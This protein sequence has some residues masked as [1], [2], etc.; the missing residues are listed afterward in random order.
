MIT[1]SPPVVGAPRRRGG[2]ARDGCPWVADLRD[3]LV[4]HPHRRRG[5]AARAREGAGRPRGRAARR[6]PGRRDRRAS[7]RR[8]PRRCASSTRRAGRDDRERL[9]LRRLRRARVHAPSD[10]RFR[11]THAGSFF[12]KRD[13]RPF[14]TALRDRA[15]RRRRA[16]PRRLPLD[17]PRVGG[18]AGL[19]DR[20]ELIPYAPHRRLARAAARLRGAAAPD[21]GGRR[22]R[23]GRA[24]REG[25]RVPRGRAADPRAR[26]AG[27]RGGGAAARDGRRRRGRA[28]RRRRDRARARGAARDRWRAG[29]LAGDARSRTSGGEG[30]APHARRGARASCSRA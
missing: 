19:G 24:L 10:D 5:A 30:L 25:L 4:A 11:I 22:P 9:R 17:R 18:G 2:Q 16:L 1:T 21:P 13:P 20:L 23:Q 7:P 12:G 27:R 3:S 14:L 8:S 6:P 29:A 26:A 15:R 28:R